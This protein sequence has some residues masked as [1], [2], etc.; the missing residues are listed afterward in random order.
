MSEFYGLVDEAFYNNIIPKSVWEFIR[1]N[2]PTIPTFYALPKIHKEGP[3]RGRPIISGNNSLTESASRLVDRILKPFVESLSSY[4]KDAMSFLQFVD[5][6]YAPP[7]SLL[8]TIDIEC[9][10]NSTPFGFTSNYF[11]LLSKK[12]KISRSLINSL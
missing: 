6:L 10:Y 9:L 5:G 3:L 4:V 12:T 11:F 7:D 8:V 1:I 2:N